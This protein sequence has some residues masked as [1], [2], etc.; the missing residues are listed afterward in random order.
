[1]NRDQIIQG[2]TKRAEADDR[3]AALF[4]GGSL[5]KGVGDDWSDAD[6]ILAA[7]PQH[8]AALNAEIRAWADGIAT[9]VL[10]KQPYPGV[11]LYTAV[12]DEWLRFDLTVTIPGQVIGAQ[13]TLKP[14]V[15]H[16]GVW[17]G[18]P[19]QLPAKPIDPAAVTALIEESLRILG[20]LP[21][22]LG[23]GEFA[24]GVTGA[25][26]IRQQLIALMILE[27]EPPLPPGALHL[28][29]L[30]SPKD[31]A[32]VEA[33]PGVVAT[34][35]SVIA[36]N[37]AYAEALLPRARAVARRVGAVWPQ[38]LEA[39]CARQWRTLDLDLPGFKG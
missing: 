28:A 30:I 20:L 23:R 11:P 19:E 18:L 17:A 10:W 4:L 16:A 29:R 22:A 2:F 15:D 26:L 38:A 12:T 21:M 34:R 1:M 25:G 7:R 6:M 31:L 9:V 33:L 27:T 5:G 36:A 8:H 3:V 37:V 14:L 35:A 39:A 13:A 32:T 24:T